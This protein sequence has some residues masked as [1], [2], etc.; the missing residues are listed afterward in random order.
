MNNYQDAQP[1]NGDWILYIAIARKGGHQQAQLCKWNDDFVE[2]F[3]E[4]EDEYDVFWVGAVD[5]GKALLRAQ[6]KAKEDERDECRYLADEARDAAI[7]LET[8][9]FD[10]TDA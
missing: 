9:L 7:D 4:A 2:F 8:E 3:K 6:I 5:P 10:L 1:S